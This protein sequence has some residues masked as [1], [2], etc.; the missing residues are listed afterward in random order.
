[1]DA[2]MKAGRRRAKSR[3]RQTRDFLWPPRS[4]ISGD[5]GEGAGPLRPEEF[6]KFRFITDPVCN[7]CGVPQ[8]YDAG[9]EAECLACIAR[10]PRWGRARA[11]F[12]YD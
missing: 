6:T 2:D 5:R 8:D 7:R 9:P 4:L 12:V 10:P 3:F 11:A 1:M